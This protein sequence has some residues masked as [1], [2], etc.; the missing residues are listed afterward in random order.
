MNLHF[1]DTDTLRAVLTLATQAPSIHNSQP[2]RWRVGDRVLQLHV[3]PSLQLPHADPDGRDL[4]VSCG[5]ALN[6]CV[7][8]LAVRGWRAKVH[9]LPDPADTTHLATIEVDHDD[10]GRPD[11]VDIVLAA[12]IT[13]RRTD[14]RHYTPRP[15]PAGHIAL[16]G[17]R[18]AR[19]GVM[20]RRFDTLENLN[21]A[22]TQAF[23]Q[24]AGDYDYLREL[25][26]W[27][28]RRGSVAGVPADATPAKHPGRLFAGSSTARPTA[29]M[30]DS[31]VMLALGT[32]AD[33][34]L[35]RLRAGEATSMAL[36][37]AT[38]MGLASCP[39]TEPLQ[40]AHTRQQIRADVFG[41]SGYP[42]MLLRLG[43]A[44]VT[45]ERL[46]PTPRR[47]L[48]DVVTWPALVQRC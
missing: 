3:D 12:A 10:A 40:I 42:Q 22:V 36:L 2:W 41:E 25:T 20:L 16:M 38:A 47:R 18:A 46:P 32:A 35:A 19:H 13:R 8:A 15:I 45:A 27:T 21:T 24:H 23:W 14:R 34:L 5:A 29:P 43:W 4:I 48:D 44:P 6:H 26:V 33:D 39:V 17:A 31:A 30:P 28:G 9:R 11:E 7:L 1:P 37:T